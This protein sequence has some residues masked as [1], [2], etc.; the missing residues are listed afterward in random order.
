MLPP[1]THVHS[2]WSWDAVDGSMERTCAEAVRVGLPAIAFTEHTDF[3]SWLVDP[4]AVGALPAHLRGMVGPDGLLRHP[5]LDVNGYLESLQRCRDRFPEL[6][7]FSGLEVGEAHWCAEPVRALLASE[8]FERVLGSL[9]S[10]RLDGEYRLID[11]LRPRPGS[12]WIL[13]EYLAELL[14][15]VESSDAFLVLAH[16]DYPL[17]RWGPT[18]GAYRPAAFEEQYRAVLRA[19][20]Q[21]GRVLEVNTRVPLHPEVVRWWHEV[22]GT[23]VAFGSDAHV[24]WAVGSGFQEAAAMVEAHG[25]RAGRHPYDFWVRG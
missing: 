3:T 14:R 21:G 24:P 12:A 19:L 4:T 25:F 5:P 16:I 15:M 6:R 18:E 17:R 22:G 9:H 10:L 7:I 1:D 20:A 13:R 8:P 2:E 23:A 11:N